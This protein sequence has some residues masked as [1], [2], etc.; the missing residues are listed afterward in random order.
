MKYILSLDLGG[1]N[2]RCALINSDLD[3]IKVVYNTT[4]GGSVNRFLEDVKNLI[5]EID[6]KS[7][8]V[9]A[10]VIGVPGR[11]RANGFID[12]LPNVHIKN[13][14]LKEH[15]ESVFNIVTFVRN[16]AEIAAVAEAIAGAG[17]SYNSTYFIT[18][19]TGIGG[20]LFENGRIKNPSE[21]IGHTL[22]F[23][24]DE[25]FELEKI[26]SGRGLTRLLELNN[27]API[28]A[29]TFFELVGKKDPLVMDVYF[30]WVN[31]VASLIN[32]VY[33]VFSPEIFVL[34]GGVMK[35]S[36]VF[37]EDLRRLT[38]PA[39]LVKAYFEQDSGLIGAAA[40]GFLTV[41]K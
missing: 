14:P 19:S 37:L 10:I 24:K 6:Y 12:E 17:R 9:G 1:T 38:T 30:D 41:G 7:Y 23:Y 31:L 22:V 15:I 8:N 25:Y 35:S 21:E 5:N 29:R 36:D 28:D 27:I 26:A 13:I 20:C 33:K 18:I 16:D 3:I 39:L 32:Y 2:L 11:V 4:T 40:Y 34:T